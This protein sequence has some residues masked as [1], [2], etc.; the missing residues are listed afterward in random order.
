MIYDSG[1]AKLF[2]LRGCSVRSSQSR[3]AQVTVATE[4]P[5][6]AWIVGIRN[7]DCRCG[8]KVSNDGRARGWVPL[9]TTRDE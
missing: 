9:G 3:H 6:T 1:D 5:D 4:E 8:H 2:D 7:A